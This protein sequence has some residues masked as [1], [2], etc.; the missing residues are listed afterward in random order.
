MQPGDDRIV[1]RIFAEGEW[2]ADT[3]IHPGGDKDDVESGVD[4]LLQRDSTGR[5]FI[6]ASSIAGAARGALA[7]KF[8][9]YAKYAEGIAA[10]PLELKAL[11]GF[12][13]QDDGF[14]SALTVQDAPARDTPRACV[15]DGVRIEAKT[16]LA[17]DHAKYNYEVLPAGSTFTMRLWLD[18]YHQPAC[19]ADP[20]ELRGWFAELLRAF[21]VQDGSDAAVLL[22]ARTRR[23]LGVGAVDHWTVRRLRMD[24]GHRG[25]VLA[26]L[27]QEP[28]GGEAVEL[29]NLG[30][31]PRVPVGAGSGFFEIRATL[32]LRTSVLVRSAGVGAGQPDALHLTENGASLAP[33]SSLA[34]VLRHR[35]QRIAR[36]LGLDDSVVVN[37]MFGPLG[38]DRETKLSGSR[39]WVSERAVENGDCMQQ[40]R[41]AIDRFTG[42]ARDSAL[43]EEAAYW[44]READ[45]HLKDFTVRLER[46]QDAEAWLLLLAFKD[47]WLGDL[48]IGGGGGVGRGVFTGVSATLRH[49]KV[50]GVCS[51]EAKGDPADVRIEGPWQAL[52]EAVRA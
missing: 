11:F 40:G 20:E 24:A 25:E 7:R 9:S 27:R 41:V 47:L 50:D 49:T 22:G 16:G 15:R 42:G 1:E 44:P 19:N 6:P 39:V 52:E 26:W 43:F 23:G 31:R 38:I 45:S 32:R 3:A 21:Q 12:A 4:M 28:Q 10:E 33:G 48:P 34:G 5:Y 29:D 36:T 35:V 17:A 51:L 2:R 18:V 8:L 37:R 14:G 13:A 30:I 46:P